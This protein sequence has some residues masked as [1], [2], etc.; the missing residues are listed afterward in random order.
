MGRVD[1]DASVIHRALG[2]K[3]DPSRP[4]PHSH[5]VVKDVVHIPH[6]HFF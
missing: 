2:M 6:D 1:G 5:E 3:R 4:K